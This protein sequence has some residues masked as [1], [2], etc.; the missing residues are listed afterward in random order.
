MKRSLEK[1]AGLYWNLSRH[2]ERVQ[3]QSHWADSARWPRQRWLEYG[4]FNFG[5]VRSFFQQYATPEI[6]DG[7]ALKTA[8]DWGCGGGANMNALCRRFRHVI[9]IDISTPTLEECAR[10]LD[11]CGC[12]NYETV[13]VNASSPG[14]VVERLGRDTVDLFFSVSVFQHF[15]SKAYTK[16]VLE[17]AA[18]LMRKGGHGLVQV[19][20]FDGSEKLRQKAGDYA[21]N[22]IYMT[23]FTTVE[24]S[25]VLAETG[26]TLLGSKQGLDDPEDCHEY[27]F[28]RK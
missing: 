13:F 22:V 1:D 5:L 9:G 19:R 28:F 27:F 8:L 7:F 11:R 14:Q 6:A 20:Y 23:S 2:D 4:E 24:F 15:P 12:S 17:A 26:F 3:D 16:D 25:T 21:K 10:Q 18:G